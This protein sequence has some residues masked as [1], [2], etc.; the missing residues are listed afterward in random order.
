VEAPVYTREELDSALR[1]LALRIE[2][3]LGDFSEACARLSRVRYE[4][5]RDLSV[6]A[7]AVGRL[8]RA[9]E[10]L[11]STLQD[12]V[13]EMIVSRLR[14]DTDI[15]KYEGAFGVKFR[16]RPERQL[17]VVL[18]R[19]GETVRPV[20]IWSDYVRVGYCEGEPE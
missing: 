5:E 6:S 17:G 16:C 4:L 20:V 3:I 7:G 12:A 19:D 15:E 13:D 1:E 11:R 9:V 8:N 10:E 2:R 14:L 18:V